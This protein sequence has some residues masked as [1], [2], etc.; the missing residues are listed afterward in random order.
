MAFKVVLGTPR[1]VAVV[2]ITP[3]LSRKTRR[4][5]SLSICSRVELSVV[6]AVVA[7]SS[8][9]G[10]RRVGPLE[11]ITDLS[12]KLSS[13][14]TFPGHGQLSRARI[15][16]DGIFSIFR[17]IFAAYF[18]VKCRASKGMSS[19]WSRNGG[20]VIGKALLQTWLNRFGLVGCI[21]TRKRPAMFRGRHFEDVII[22][23]CVRWYLRYS[24]TYR[25]LEEIMLER[26]LSVDHVTIWRWVQRYAPVLNRR[27]RREMRRPNRSW[28]VDETYVKVAGNWAYLYRAVDSAR[29][30]RSSSCCRPIARKPDRGEVVPAPGIIRR[31]THAARDP[32]WTAIRPTPAPSPS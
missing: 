8:A 30:I 22:L 28:R 3:P 29:G 21:V 13:S 9:N 6:S 5:Y 19:G 24:L 15:V 2:L 10:A 11:R 4:M 26:N 14:R 16:S 17:S 18:L 20:G 25:D 1:R 12:M 31:G 27:I 23:L 32:T 7:R